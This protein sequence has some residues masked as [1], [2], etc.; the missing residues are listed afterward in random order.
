[1]NE[2]FA[3][4]GFAKWDMRCESSIQNLASGMILIAPE[5]QMISETSGKVQMAKQRYMIFKA[6]RMKMTS[7]MKSPASAKNWAIHAT[8]NSF[9]LTSSLLKSFVIGS[10]GT[11]LL[12]L[13]F[14]NRLDLLEP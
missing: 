1:M 4:K 6:I 8:R 13:V 12:C 14:Q 3:I 11:F 5:R 10:S 2:D 7:P 9:A